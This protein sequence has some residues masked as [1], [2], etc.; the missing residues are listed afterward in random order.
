MKLHFTAFAFVFCINAEAQ[1]VISQWNFN[2][3][4]PPDFILTTGSTVS[5]MG[6]GSIRLTGNTGPSN[7]NPF[8][9]GS[10]NDYFT[11][12]LDNTAWN[13]TKFPAQGTASKTGGIQFTVSSIGFE[14]IQL[15]FDEKHSN[16][17]ANTTVVQ[18]N[19]DT[20]NASGWIDFQ[21]NKITASPF[22]S[23]WQTH[24][25][26]LSSIISVNNQPR[27]GFRIVSAFD[28]SDGANY[29][30]TL[31][32]T[33]ASYSA[34]GGTIRWDMITITGTPTGAC[35]LPTLK[36]GNVTILNAG[37]NQIT[38]SFDRGNG[39]GVLILCRE[40]YAVNSYPLSGT[41]YAASSIFG[42]G[43]QAGTGNYAVYNSTQPG[44]N[45]V[46]VTGLTPSKIY[47]FAAFEYGAANLCYLQPPLYFHKTTGGTLFKPGELLLM[48]FDTRIPG[49]GTGNDKIYISSIVDILPGT[50][51]SLVSSR[52]EAGAAP[53]VR[54]N[55]WF[56]S[57][58]YINKD[59]DVQEFTWTGATIIPA[60]AIIG[61]QDKSTETDRYDS[62][63]VNGIYQPLFISDKQKGAFNIPTATTKGEQFYLVQGSFFPSGDFYTDRFNTLFGKPLFGMTLLTNWVPFSTTPVTAN[64]GVAFR[65]SRIP[66]DILCLNIA[67]TVDAVGAAVYTGPLTNTKRNFKAAFTAPANWLWK[68]GDATLNITENFTP[69]YGSEI[70][71]PLTINS[72]PDGDGS[73]VGDKNPDWFDCA[74]WEGKYVPDSLL[75]VFINAPQPFN[76]IINT[77]ENLE[78]A[79]LYSNL[80]HTRNLHINATATLTV[81]S[82]SHLGIFNQMTFNLPAGSQVPEQRNTLNLRGKEQT[83]TGKYMLKV[84]TPTLKKRRISFH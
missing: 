17:S 84:N 50:Q 37:N 46:T 16:S 69:P 34:T 47:Y 67:N 31:N 18:Y 28:P 6:N 82:N 75:D 19:P 59:P 13:I 54:T 70:G 72:T 36:G 66:P 27:L 23:D 53:N 9:D 38:F 58:D 68:V 45:T 49:S 14:N 40:G 74:N 77:T 78:P 30:S 3:P 57:G 42:S 4:L 51:F 48:G 29:I 52:Y 10:D 11:N 2:T 39:D 83:N 26:N 79:I 56:N 35:S 20:L 55:Q 22:S 43:N 1:N 63:T 33:A 73:W 44:R 64:T 32:Q 25:A 80:A 41:A 65:E 62:V 60:G 71:Q 5:S 12:G 81:T 8:N 76:P 7:A 21:L 61:I 24:F 15:K